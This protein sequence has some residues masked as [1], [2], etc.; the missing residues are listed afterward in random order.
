MRN[1]GAH[2]R[3]R[4]RIY[5]AGA[6][7]SGSILGIVVSLATLATGALRNAVSTISP[8][9]SY[10]PV[11]VILYGAYFSFIVALVYVPTFTYLNAV[12]RQIH[13]LFFD[14]TVPTDEGW[15]D[16][17]DKQKAFEDYLQLHVLPFDSLKTGLLI[18]APLLG[19]VTSL[20]IGG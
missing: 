3:G 1:S 13:T 6:H 20:L 4:Y 16:W 2:E 9:N 18:L 15:K 10:P 19:S 17:N 14:L 11:L 7:W 5:G 8:P 12:G